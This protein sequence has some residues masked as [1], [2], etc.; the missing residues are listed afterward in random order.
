[1]WLQPIV[2]GNFRILFSFTDYFPS[3]PDF[4]I[5]IGTYTQPLT[6][7]QNIGSFRL[8]HKSIYTD[9]ISL[10]DRDTYVIFERGTRVLL[11]VVSGGVCQVSHASE[12]PVGIAHVPPSGC[13]GAAAGENGNCPAAG[14]P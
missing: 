8:W 13:N 5:L 3:E 1:M 7:Q 9:E 6:S 12:N 4:G 14:R 11:L 10:Q 2:L